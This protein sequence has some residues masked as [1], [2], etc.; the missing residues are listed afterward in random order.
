V[1][2]YVSRWAASERRYWPAFY[3]RDAAGLDWHDPEY[4]PPRWH[5]E[6]PASPLW[7]LDQ[8]AQWARHVS[9]LPGTPPGRYTLWGEVFDIDSLAIA[10]RLDV[11]GNAVAP[12]FELGTLTVSRPRAPADFGLDPTAATALGVLRLLGASLDR[13]SAQSGDT[14]GLTLYWESAAATT[15]DLQIEI[16]LARSGRPPEVRVSLP[17]VA[18]YG[19]Q[20][21]QPGDRW[22]GQYRL[23][24]PAALPGG[25]YGVTVT[26]PGTVGRAEIG[27]LSVSAPARVYTAPAMPHTA[28]ARLRVWRPWQATPRKPTTGGW[29]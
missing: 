15:E 10:S 24:L 2:L 6:P 23:R 13:T 4:L 9:L 1:A 3:I 22:R 11:A 19:T 26:L 18:G 29:R 27:R 16:A 21:W 17:P 14:L 28:G 5:R 8:Y 12:R 7:P 20:A 25:D